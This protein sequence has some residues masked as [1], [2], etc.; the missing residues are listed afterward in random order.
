MY[1]WFVNVI[2][3]ALSSFKYKIMEVKLLT[4]NLKSK[5]KSKMNILRPKNLQ[6]LAV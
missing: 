4:D 5:W 3:D 2:K 1:V 6:Y